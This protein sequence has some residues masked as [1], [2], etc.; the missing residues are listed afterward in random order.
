[1]HPRISS[2]TVRRFAAV[3]PR[4]PYGLTPEKRTTLSM[5]LVLLVLSG[6]CL[7][8]ACAVVTASNEVQEVLAVRVLAGAGVAAAALA[9]A[10]WSEV[11]IPAAGSDSAPPEQQ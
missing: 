1:M 2:V 10:S 3:L 11:L 4:S 5:S 7:A 8:L 9:L 6:F